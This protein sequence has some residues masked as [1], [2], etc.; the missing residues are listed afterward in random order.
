MFE[1]NAKTILYTRENYSIE[2]ELYKNYIE[3]R[4]SL[5]KLENMKYSNEDKLLD[6][7]EFKQGF[8]A[9]IKIMSSILIDL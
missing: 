8:I 7:E 5:G 1:K 4:K 9:G 3:M 6:S 2:E